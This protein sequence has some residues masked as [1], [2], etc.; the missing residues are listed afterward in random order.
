MPICFSADICGARSVERARNLFLD[1]DSDSR[2]EFSKLS[3]SLGNGSFF[4]E[5]VQLPLVITAC[6][7]LWRESR[8]LN[9]ETNWKNWE[10]ELK[11]TA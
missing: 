2:Q 3:R 1:S 9:P 10:L 6:C 11:E 5:G 8:R 7:L 4:V